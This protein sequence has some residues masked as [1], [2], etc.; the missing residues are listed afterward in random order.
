MGASR[1][2]DCE[3]K[4]FPYRKR[5]AGPVEIGNPDEGPRPA[6]VPGQ[7]LHSLEAAPADDHGRALGAV[8]IRTV[9]A[10]DEISNSRRAV[11][12]A[13]SSAL[14]SAVCGAGPFAAPR[15][16]ML[17]EVLVRAASNRWG[18]D[19]DNV[20]KRKIWGPLLKDL[21]G[22]SAEPPVV[23]VDGEIVVVKLRSTERER[24]T[25]LGGR[26][27]PISVRTIASTM[28]VNPSSLGRRTGFVRR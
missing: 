27:I 10:I 4:E 9:G 6:V 20:A 22:D 13:L 1:Y 11:I 19:E 3:A 2:Q 17:K 26:K 14:A 16:E 7:R 5:F 24:V 21:F 15:S 18:A 12:D 25:P 28:P 23:R 8:H